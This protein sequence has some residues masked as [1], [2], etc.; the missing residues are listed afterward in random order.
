MPA[1][2]LMQDSPLSLQWYS[3]DSRVPAG[4]TITLNDKAR[5]RNSNASMGRSYGSGG[6]IMLCLLSV[7][8]MSYA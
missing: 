5:Y 6:G 3:S 7:M 4:T 2:C 1:G 8:A